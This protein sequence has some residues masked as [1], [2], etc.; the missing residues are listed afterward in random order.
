MACKGGGC[1]HSLKA[2]MAR[3]SPL[4]GWAPCNR[5]YGGGHPA[6]A[7]YGGGL[8]TG[9]SEELGHRRYGGGHPAI[10]AYGGGHPADPKNWVYCRVWGWAPWRSWMAI[11]AY[12][13]GHPAGLNN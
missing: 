13:G 6:I 9:R 11:A 8:S 7:A 3:K 2:G 4:W 12:G 5:R 10:A 1:E